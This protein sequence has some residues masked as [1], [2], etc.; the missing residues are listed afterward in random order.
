MVEA[1][2]ILVQLLNY[3]IIWFQET[4]IC[5]ANLFVCSFSL[6]TLGNEPTLKLKLFALISYQL[7]FGTKHIAKL[8]A[9]GCLHLIESL[10]VRSCLHL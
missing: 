8:V 6:L 1:V 4:I 3:E 2:I 10:F 9:L 5:T 7:A